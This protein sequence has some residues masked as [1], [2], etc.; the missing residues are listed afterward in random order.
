MYQ[1]TLKTNS[2]EMHD[3]L[4]N[5]FDIVTDSRDFLTVEELTFKKTSPNVP[6]LGIE[7]YIDSS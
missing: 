4:L 2:V 3:S 6:I 5:P 7:F 1:A